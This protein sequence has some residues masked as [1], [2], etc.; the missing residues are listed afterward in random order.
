VSADLEETDQPAA[1]P[2]II[3][4]DDGDENLYSDE[5]A[6]PLPDEQDQQS[7]E[8]QMPG[9]ISSTPSTALEDDLPAPP[10]DRLE[11]L[12][13]F[14]LNQGW[15]TDQWC[16]QSIQKE[17]FH[18]K[19]TWPDEKE[20]AQTLDIIL[21][22]SRALEEYSQQN[23]DDSNP[24]EQNRTESKGFFARLKGMFSS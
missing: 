2:G 3:P 14:L 13:S 18:I 23:Q 20:L 10:V 6:A 21:S 8:P 15:E 11:K 1:D 5:P 4:F 22:L 17:C 19:D 7:F 12:Q 16:L 24:P 9:A